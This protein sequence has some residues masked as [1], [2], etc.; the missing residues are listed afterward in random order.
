MVSF[1]KQM[2]SLSFEKTEH[3]CPRAGQNNT[4]G[5][6]STTEHNPPQAKV[7]TNN[8]KLAR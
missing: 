6:S 7:T 8:A 2:N 3:K 1:G 4:K 5:C